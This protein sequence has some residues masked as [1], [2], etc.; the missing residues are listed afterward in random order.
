[1]QPVLK[2]SDGQ[3]VEKEKRG[4][5]SDSLCDLSGLI[6]PFLIANNFDLK[7]RCP[8]QWQLKRILDVFAVIFGGII[9]SP[10]LALVIFAIKADSKGPILFKQKRIGLHGK[11]FYMYKFRSMY[12]DAEQKLE[13]LLK[14]NETNDL[15]FKME[16]DPRITKVGKIIRKLSIDELPQ[17]L[18]VLKGEMSLV[19]PRP[20]IRRELSDYE[21]WHYLRF[22]T[23]PGLTG[24]WQVSGRS[25][26]KDFNTVVKMDYNY[27][28]KWS[29]LL[30]MKLLLKT[31]PVVL[32]GE[33]AG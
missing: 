25:K 10:L 6:N 16:N 22:G 20:P 30:D 29:F 19:G 33:G 24:V 17:L 12:I 4:L 14:H 32:S 21:N 27:I 8:F 11:E 5:G 9:I 2:V 31:V 28:K 13:E 7:K 3:L 1:M 23:L 18:N 26:I 15:M